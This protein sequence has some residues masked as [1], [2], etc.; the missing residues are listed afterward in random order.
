[1]SRTLCKDGGS[2]AGAEGAAGIVEPTETTGQVVGLGDEGGWPGEITT[3][4]QQGG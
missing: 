1:M 3:K 2:R 4:K